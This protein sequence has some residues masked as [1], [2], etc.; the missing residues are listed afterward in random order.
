M[1]LTLW[2]R[3]ERCLQS[4]QHSSTGNKAPCMR[5]CRVQTGRHALLQAMGCWDLQ[6][7]VVLEHAAPAGVLG[8]MWGL[9]AHTGLAILPGPVCFLLCSSINTRAGLLSTNNVHAC[10][11]ETRWQQ[12]PVEHL[13]C[14]AAAA[15]MANRVPENRGKRWDPLNSHP[16]C[17]CKQ[18]R[19]SA[20]GELRCLF[21]F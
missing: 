20:E 19:R 6:A 7:G 16:H 11:R 14:A 4:A 1:L 8:P 18:R 12:Q 15:A 5:R 9:T 3:P 10:V 17:S 2:V 13:P 21:A